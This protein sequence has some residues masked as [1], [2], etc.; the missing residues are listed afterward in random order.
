M[1]EQGDINYAVI[2]R[3]HGQT[4]SGGELLGKDAAI[5]HLPLRWTIFFFRQDALSL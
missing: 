3:T 4:R 2:I 1:E 5:F